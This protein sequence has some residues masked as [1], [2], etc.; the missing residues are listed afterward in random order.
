VQHTVVAMSIYYFLNH[1][2]IGDQD[3]DWSQRPIHLGF[4]MLFVYTLLDCQRV[5]RLWQLTR[6]PIESYVYY[7]YLHYRTDVG[8]AVGNV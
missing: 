6:R 8:I 4:V 2:G 3:S 7:Q 1:F 5:G